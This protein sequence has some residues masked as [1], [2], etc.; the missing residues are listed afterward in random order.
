MAK[1]SG[2]TSMRTEFCDPD[3]KNQKWVTSSAGSGKSGG[4]DKENT[5]QET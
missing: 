4:I 2:K 3:L 5:G 1:P